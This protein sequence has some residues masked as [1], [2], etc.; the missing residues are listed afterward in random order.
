MYSYLFVINIYTKKNKGLLKINALCNEETL[1]D[2][3][4]I[5]QCKY[6][7]IWFKI[8][9]IFFKNLINI[10][11]QILNEFKFYSSLLTTFFTTLFTTF[12]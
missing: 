12:F 1:Y 6:E 3:D 4:K 10:I 11:N 9:E 5:K 2:C 7:H 8:K